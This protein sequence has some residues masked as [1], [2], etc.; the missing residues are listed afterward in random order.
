MEEWLILT[1]HPGYVFLHLFYLVNNLGCSWFKGFYFSEIFFCCTKFP[2]VDHDR[3]KLQVSCGA[4]F[5]IWQT[6]TYSLADIIFRFAHIPFLHRKHSELQFVCAFCFLHWH[7]QAKTFFH[8]SFS[9]FKI[10]V[11]HSKISLQSK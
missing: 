2:F 11:R 4:I 9:A 3:S 8:V 6:G 1:W 5:F 10:L 7:S